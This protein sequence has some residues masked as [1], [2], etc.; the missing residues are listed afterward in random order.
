MI[1]IFRQKIAVCLSVIEQVSKDIVWCV[2]TTWNAYKVHTIAA[3]KSVMRIQALIFSRSKWK[4]YV[5]FTTAKKDKRIS[6]AQ[7]RLHE[8]PNPCMII[9]VSK[10]AL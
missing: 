8:E 3:K 5:N 9:L 2:K 4:I 10:V 6:R 7:T 1:S